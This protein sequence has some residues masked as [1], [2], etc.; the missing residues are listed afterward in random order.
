M[1]I[2][3]EG[4]YKSISTFEW[5]DV[6]KFVIIS[7]A[8]GTGKTQLLE[9]IDSFFRKSSHVKNLT[10]GNIAIEDIDAA[11][12]DI[13]FLRDQWYLKSGTLVSP[14]AYGEQ[15]KSSYEQY[16]NSG[17]N[18]YNRNS[19]NESLFKELDSKIN[20]SSRVLV[21]QEE[22]FKAFPKILKFDPNSLS[23]EIASQFCNYRIR[24]LE[25]L[26]DGG[27]RIAFVRK[28]GERPWDL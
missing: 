22:F 15:R 2:S 7:G 23:D 8:N 11:E 6:P 16:L 19:Q 21:G 4:S 17:R 13:L 12:K 27:D 25:Y 9:L 1:N 28:N 10:D 24:E 3:F 5:K 20:K 18:P 14:S 26:A